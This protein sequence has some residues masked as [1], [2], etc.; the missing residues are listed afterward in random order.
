MLVVFEPDTVIATEV[1]ATLWDEED[2]Y[3][4]EDIMMSKCHILTL[5]AYIHVCTS[6]MVQIHVNIH[7]QCK[8]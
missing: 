8:Y 4:A 5:I 2:P 6:T 1:L 7:V 3:N